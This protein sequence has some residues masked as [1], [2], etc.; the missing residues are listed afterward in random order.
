MD[1]LQRW[2][3]RRTNL[4]KVGEVEVSQV[5][6][7]YFGKNG[8]YTEV[9][10]G[11][12]RFLCLYSSAEMGVMRVLGDATMI[13]LAIMESWAR[14]LPWS[15]AQYL[16]GTVLRDPNGVIAT[17]RYRS[18]QF[19]QIKRETLDSMG[20]WEENTSGAVLRRVNCFGDPELLEKKDGKNSALWFWP[21]TGRLEKVSL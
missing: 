7:D 17:L 18:A 1:L 14:N 3:N 6:A 13:P 12:G 19:P 2:N 8:A 5:F 4:V 9:R 20:S 10:R 11:D 16:D 21:E 15:K